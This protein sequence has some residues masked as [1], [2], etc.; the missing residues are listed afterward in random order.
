[1]PKARAVFDAINDKARE[2]VE[3]EAGLF[4]MLGEALGD[5]LSDF[6][7]SSPD[8]VTNIRTLGGGRNREILAQVQGGRERILVLVKIMRNFTFVKSALGSPAK[9]A[10]SAAMDLEFPLAPTGLDEAE[11][12]EEL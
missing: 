11:Q 10:A 7:R 2:I 6:R 9:P 12:V 4:A 5:L 1:M 8:L 3:D